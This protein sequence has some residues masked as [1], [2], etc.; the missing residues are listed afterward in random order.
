[1]SENDDPPVLQKFV[2]EDDL[3]LPSL[4][5]YPC[6]DS[7]NR[8]LLWND[9]KHAFQDIEHLNDKFGNRLLLAVNKE[10]KL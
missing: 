9:I 10:F 1:M 7:D 8:Y 6:E 2:S 4:P 3:R 5:T